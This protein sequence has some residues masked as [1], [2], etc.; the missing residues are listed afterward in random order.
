MEYASYVTLSLICLREES[1]P[2]MAVVISGSIDVGSIVVETS[3][4]TILE[5]PINNKQMYEKRTSTSVL[6]SK[7]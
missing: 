7:P 2:R 6:I 5:V 3:P 4:S 1:L